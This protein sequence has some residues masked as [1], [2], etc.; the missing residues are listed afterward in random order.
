[1]ALTLYRLVDHDRV[2][3]DLDDNVIVEVTATHPGDP[4]GDQLLYELH[5][6][7]FLVEPT[8]QEDVYRIRWAEALDWPHQITAP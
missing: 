2:Q 4:T 5:P 3:K 8:D 1:M 6:L 7:P